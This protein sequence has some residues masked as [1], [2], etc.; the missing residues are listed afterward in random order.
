LSAVAPPEAAPRAAR[1]DVWNFVPGLS[2]G[3][4]SSDGDNLEI[5]VSA[6]MYQPGGSVWFRAMVDGEVAEPSDVVFKSGSVNFD[7]V[8]N[9]T[10]VKPAVKAGQHLVEIQWR[11]GT[12]AS[13]RD[14]TLTVY[15]ASAFIGPGH[16]AVATAPSGPDIQKK[17]SS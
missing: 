2:S 16:L 9:F 13:I 15:S 4:A 1:L 17:N 7:G 14:R 6:E 10:F 11:T 3:V 12:P 5:T 8:R